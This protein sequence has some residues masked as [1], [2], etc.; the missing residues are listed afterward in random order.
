MTSDVSEVLLPCPFCGTPDPEYDNCDHGSG[1][2]YSCRGCPVRVKVG[3]NEDLKVAWNTR[4]QPAVL[5]VPG[6]RPIAEAPKDGTP[7]MGF[8][9][10][11]DGKVKPG[12][13]GPTLFCDGEWVDPEDIDDGYADPTHWMPLP[14]PPRSES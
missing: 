5:A 9:T 12:C 11:S 4:A 6:W 1:Q 13:Y 3:Y 10:P 14:A 2:W 8:W 7:I